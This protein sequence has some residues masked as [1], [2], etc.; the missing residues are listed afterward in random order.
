MT[1]LFERFPFCL[2]EEEINYREDENEVQS[3]EE[4]I[5]S[6]SD[7]LEHGSGDHDLATSEPP[8]TICTGVTHDEEVE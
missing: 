5:C 1:Y 4:Y 8:M 3:S 6:P 2:W 7:V